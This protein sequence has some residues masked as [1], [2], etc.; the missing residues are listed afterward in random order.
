MVTPHEQLF[1]VFLKLSGRRVLVVGAGAVAVGKIRAL[2]AAGAMVEVVAPNATVNIEAIGA[3]VRKRKFRPDDLN[4]AWMVIAAAPPD[5]NRA[6]SDEAERRRIF[7]NAVDD[8]DNASAYLG[9]VVRRAGVTFAIS[10]DGRAPALAGLLR[11]G[12]DAVL[13][14]SELASWMREADRLKRHWRAEG[15]PMESRRPALLKALLKQYE[16]QHTGDS[17]G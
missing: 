6:V 12:L 7:V 11:E 17:T 13:P 1:P 15:T 2:V 3:R 4:G 16:G 5:V 9:G 14:K 8:P 10:T